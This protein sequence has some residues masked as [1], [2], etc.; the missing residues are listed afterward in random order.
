[1]N[2][3]FPK[4]KFYG[5]LILTI[6]FLTVS[7]IGFSQADVCKVTRNNFSGDGGSSSSD[8]VKSS[9][10]GKTIVMN[11]GFETITIKLGSI[12]AATADYS[13][14]NYTETPGS[15]QLSV[16]IYNP[17]GN[18]VDTYDFADDGKTASVCN[19]GN[20]KITVTWNNV[21]FKATANAKQIIPTS[22]EVSA[23]GAPKT[24]NSNPS[25]NTTTTSDGSGNTVTSSSSSSSSSTV[26]KSGAGVD[27]GT[28]TTTSNNT[29]APVDPDAQLKSE[30]ASYETQLAD[31][32]KSIT[33]KEY[34]LNE[35]KNNKQSD[36]IETVIANYDIEI[37]KLKRDETKFALERSNKTLN[38]TITVDSKQDYIAKEE[39]CRLKVKSIE[40]KRNPVAETKALNTAS[41]K[42][43]VDLNANASRLDSEI[44]A[45]APKNAMDTLNLNVKQIELE[46]TKADTDKN[47]LIA[48]RTDKAL[49]GRLSDKAALEY[50]TKEDE[51]QAK[52]NNCNSRIEEQNKLIKAESKKVRKENNKAKV[53]AVKVK[54][55]IK[56]LKKDI[57]SKEKEVA[58]HEK[59]GNAEKAAKS[60]QELADMQ[61][62]M[63]DLE[64]QLKK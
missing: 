47:K 20:G 32:T 37:L 64:A 53:D 15:D 19:D 49:K 41:K 46:R 21:K 3:Q 7:A 9:N 61:K 44:K 22:I 17:S 27:N 45:S 50:K 55:K 52:I 59:K 24:N 58:K 33:A 39:Q 6:T 16:K 25:S 11:T 1:M 42:A 26:T 30:I 14:I 8:D 40:A 51:C 38:K 2:K 5:R 57:A 34:E 54:L 4:S 28:T 31:Q 13:I 43:V 18:E 35:K 62:E 10:G 29:P 36:S 23:G 60:K 12:P 63:A 56:L 48:E